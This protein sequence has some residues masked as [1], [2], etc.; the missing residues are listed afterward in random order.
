M[1]ENQQIEAQN[2]LEA[3][4]AD[5][6]IDEVLYIVRSGKEATVYCC[7]AAERA[8]RQLLAA[9]LYRPLEQRAFR[10]D[11]AYQSGRGADW[12]TRNRRAFVNKSQYGRTVQYA[13]WIGAEY[14]NLTMLHRAGADVPE[15][16]ARAPQ[17]ILMEYIG[18]ENEPAPMLVRVRMTPEEATRCLDAIIRNVALWLAH[19]RIHGDLSAYNILYWNG[20]IAVIDFP[21]AIDSRMNLNARALLRRDLENVCEYFR[22]LGVETEGVRIAENLWRS[23]RNAR[24]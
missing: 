17:G 7:R 20:R 13:T 4:F 8:G 19:D 16:I 23:Y 12:G 22:R 10:N 24:L 1:T 2:A 18:D 5:G 9:K 21:Q 3:F 14:E 6:W 11:A 15:P